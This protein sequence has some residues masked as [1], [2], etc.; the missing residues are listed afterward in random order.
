MTRKKKIILLITG[1][2]VC[3]LL[4]PVG[5]SLL[6]Q[7]HGVQNFI[8]HNAITIVNKKIQGEIALSK[9]GIAMTGTIV[10]EGLCIRDATHDTIISASKARLRIRLSELLRRNLYVPSVRLSDCSVNLVRPGGDEH[11]NIQ[12]LFSPETPPGT[13]RQKEKNKSGGFSITVRRVRCGKVR[14]L[15]DDQKNG[16]QVEARVG[17]LAIR[18]DRFKLDK[19]QFD[20]KNLD[21][22]SSFCAVRIFK[23][24]PQKEKKERTARLPEITVKSLGV[25]NTDFIFEDTVAGNTIRAGAKGITIEQGDVDLNHE[26]ISVRSV[27]IQGA[28]VGLGLT[29]DAAK[30]R[31]TGAGAKAPDRAKENRWNIAAGRLDLSESRFDFDILNKTPLQNGFDAAHMHFQDIAVRARDAFYS[32]QAIRGKLI[33]ATAKDP[34]GTD[35][36]KCAVDFAMDEQG[37]SARNLQVHTPSSSIQATLTTGFSP[38]NG[39]N[40]ESPA[41]LPVTA[42]FKQSTVGPRDVR[43]FVPI[44]SKAP[45]LKRIE[46]EVTFSGKIQGPVKSLKG[47][48]IRVSYGTTT[49]LRADFLVSGL[50]AAKKT[51]VDI[52]ALTLSTGSGDVEELLGR[53]AIPRGLSIPSR[54]LLD[55]TGSG[56]MRSFRSTLQASLDNSTVS[57]AVSLDTMQ[58]YTGTIQVND[59]DP[60]RIHSKAGDIGRMT[61]SAIIDGRGFDPKTLRAQVRIDAP[62]AHLN[63][64][65]Y[66]NINGEARIDS[67]RCQGTLS[68]ND[69]NVSLALEGDIQ[70]AKDHEAVRCK[71]DLQRADCGKLRLL[72]DSLRVSAKIE[73]DLKGRDL[74]TLSGMVNLKKMTLV[75]NGIEYRLDSLFCT[76]ATSPKNQTLTIRSPVLDARYDGAEPLDRAFKELGRV[77]L[78]SLPVK[79]SPPDTASGLR[80]LS[81]RMTIRNHPLLNGLLLPELALLE[82]VVLSADYSEADKKFKADAG[83]QRLEYNG[84]SFTGTHATVIVRDNHLSGSLTADEIANA[85]AAFTT[86]RVKG[87]SRSDRATFSVSTIGKNQDTALYAALSL[88]TL[89]SGIALALD[90]ASFY[91]G[92]YPWTVGKD[93]AVV[94][95]GKR[96]SFHNISLSRNRNSIAI[97]SHNTADRAVISIAVRDFALKFISQLLR[98]DSTFVDGTLSGTV[99]IIRGGER[100][101]LKASAGL[102]DI[103]IKND[104][105]GSLALAVENTENEKYR[106]I[107]DLTGQGNDAHIQGTVN[108]GPADPEFDIHAAIKNLAVQSLEP[109]T[110][111]AI[112][113]SRGYLQGDVVCTGTQRRPVMNG[114][115]IF[116]EVSV[117]PAVL[118]SAIRLESDTIEIKNSGLFFNNFSIKD[119]YN[120]A[121]AVSGVIAMDTTGLFWFDVKANADDFLVLNTTERDNPEFYGRVVVD[122]QATIQGTARS[123]SIDSRIALKAPSS[124]TFAVP[125]NRSK[126]DRGEG[127]V[128]FSGPEPFQAQG[129]SIDDIRNRTVKGLDLTSEIKI[130]KGVTLRLIPDPS[131]LD[132][133]VVRGDGALN[134]GLDKSGAI[135]LTGTYSLTDGSYTVTLPPLLAKKFTI[136][137]GSALS[138]NGKPTDANAAIVAQYAVSA[139]PIDLV[140]DQMAS[141][142]ADDKNLYRKPLKFLISLYLNGP[143]LKPD[144]SFALDLAPVDKG[145]LGGMI[146]AKLSQINQDPTTLNKQVFALLV[147]GKFLPDNPLLQSSGNDQLASVARSSV[148]G[149]LTAQLNQWGASLF[150]GIEL[151]VGVQS[152]GSDTASLSVGKTMVDLGVKKQ[153]FN[154]R[155]S[156]EV[157]GTFDVEGERASVKDNQ[158]MANNIGGNVA[159]EYK[160]TRDGRYSLK[161]FRHT[162]Y[163]GALD[164]QITETGAGIVYSRNFNFWRQIFKRAGKGNDEP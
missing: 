45:F 72:K 55:A 15:L 31:P 99:D 129:N 87:E 65:T 94:I 117:R 93:N 160:I 10:L 82:G 137:S 46:K 119:R 115:I 40:A 152:Y 56:G 128:V 34:D 4:A 39:K 9:I 88:R 27:L 22:D 138:W 163:E 95:A 101:V 54:I 145:A 44:L 2:F 78:G 75:K 7:V 38:F 96:V 135:N 70:T 125:K 162:Q 142:S 122:W 141:V 18:M 59:L 121:T 5:L 50:P 97:T 100:S 49:N 63:G 58:H 150:P 147:L 104:T 68:V 123:P 120:H 25:S 30:S 66:Q 143:V 51:R 124:I 146:D 53:A 35:L 61:L 24:G 47:E 116:K 127:V 106:I 114:K 90:P 62:S 41:N 3:I 159:L 13:A 1:L 74:H 133:L 14:F 48:K 42:V 161:G 105:I 118:N 149:F 86:V 110:G 77:V 91:L 154:D 111:G 108:T 156:V 71:L 139:A 80:D 20:V 43:L 109:F 131:T 112:S 126:I 8:V 136:R 130:D 98:K 57:A 79:R 84:I 33:H 64:Y 73:A 92:G 132:V 26:A 36:K 17:R 140:Y 11:L 32:A 81:L 28:E 83:V 103:V 144:I 153:L 134:L 85:Q 16:V 21:L 89:D 158:N 157:G 19:L 102:R 69:E 164:G 151:N 23:K 60:G 67:Q 29:A 37:I 52:P 107:A 76:I 155:L 148:S 113:R 6:L 12:R